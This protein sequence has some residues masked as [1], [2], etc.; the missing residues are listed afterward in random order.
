MED[1]LNAALA[2]TRADIARYAGA[3]LICYRAEAPEALV[4]MQAEAF[5][6]V[7][8]WAEDALGARLI[9]GAGVMHVTQPE[10]AL[11]AVA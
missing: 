10:P 6:P 11:A 8:A 2:E 1:E 4:A 9:L 5:D 3:D 7:L